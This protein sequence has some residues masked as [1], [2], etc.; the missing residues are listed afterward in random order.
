M[1]TISSRLMTALTLWAGLGAVASAAE[2]NIT[3]KGH[4]FNPV[5]SPDGQ[6][7]AFELNNYQGSIELYVVK[8]QGGTPM[9]SPT[10]M[11]VPGASS[12]F[13]TAASV[14]A[15]PAWHPKNQLIFEGSAAGG[16]S[17]LY[18]WAPGGQTASELLSATQAKDDLTWPAISPDGKMVAFVGSS[19]GQ[20]DVYFWDRNTN[21]VT[22]A[23]T[24]PFSE[25]APRYAPTSTELAYSRKNQGGEDLFV[26][27]AAGNTPRI[28]GNGD[29]SRPVWSGTNV[30]FYTNERGDDRWD[31]A[32]SKGAGDKQI[33]AKDIRLPQRAAPAMSPNGQW[34]AYGV[35]TPEKADAVFLTK[36]DGSATVEINTGFVAAGEPSLVNAGGRTWLAFTALPSN[37]A[38]WRGLHIIDVTDKVK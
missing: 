9:G 30:V 3:A 19:T 5:W 23:F 33:L 22:Q 37:S 38:D 25:M 4:A 20:G 8:V 10:K 15:A 12:S 14:A 34:V 26:W 24:S 27:S 32:V 16:N 36:V 2:V 11:V 31:V 35:T 6:W 7:L 17:R 28:G 21:A 18:F 13:S 29:Q 1:N